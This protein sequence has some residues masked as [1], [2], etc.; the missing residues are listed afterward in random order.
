MRKLSVRNSWGYINSSTIHL[1]NIILHC[2]LLIISLS[3]TYTLLKFTAII[4]YCY[5][6]NKSFL[7]MYRSLPF[8]SAIKNKVEHSRIVTKL[9]K[10]VCIYIQFFLLSYCWYLRYR[11][12]TIMF[13][14]EN[15][16]NGFTSSTNVVECIPFVTWYVFYNF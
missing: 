10:F 2:S 7:L 9:I 12:S 8:Y 6:Y 5:D 13:L 14:F 3:F 16:L 15:W 4:F 1:E 11:K